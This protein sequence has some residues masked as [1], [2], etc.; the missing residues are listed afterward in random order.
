M[1]HKL[2]STMDL[3]HI[4][5]IEICTYSNELFQARNTNLLRLQISTE[6]IIMSGKSNFHELYCKD[7]LDNTS[8]VFLLVNDDI[9]VLESWKDALLHLIFTHYATRIDLAPLELLWK[10]WTH[11]VLMYSSTLSGMEDGES[12]HDE[13]ITVSSCC[14]R[15]ALGMEE[16]S[17]VINKVQKLNS[18]PDEEIKLENFTFDCFFN[19]FLQSW[20]RE[21]ITD[22]FYSHTNSKG[23]MN[24]QEL[25][26]FLHTSI[27]YFTNPSFPTHS[28]RNF[29][30]PE[31]HKTLRHIKYLHLERTQHNVMNMSP[32]KISS[33]QKTK[34]QKLQLESNLKRSQS[35]YTAG[36]TTVDQTQERIKNIEDEVFAVNSRN[37]FSS[38]TSSPMHQNK[39]D[40]EGNKGNYLP[41]SIT[42][43]EFMEIVQRHETNQYA[44]NKCLLTN[45][46]FYRLLLSSTYRELC[47]RPNV[48][49][50]TLDQSTITSQQQ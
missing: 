33:I 26:S 38:L 39:I 18:F 27:S 45:E 21:D 43:K 47:V 48:P 41:I 32:S 12:L 6:G 46:G 16:S 40:F 37:E 5:D 11:L 23:Y 22:L 13:N 42:V 50:Y 1:E 15:A 14:L 31:K 28:S 3:M 35:C 20:P 2:V 9:T 30:T 36:E 10:Q 25:N 24:C 29:K 49:S 8:I 44:A 7:T 17:V 4:E 34:S 19:L